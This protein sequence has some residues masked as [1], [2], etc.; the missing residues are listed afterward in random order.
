MM[1]EEF[2]ARANFEVMPNE[3]MDIEKKYADGAFGNC[4]KDEFCKLWVENGGIKEVLQARKDG[5]IELPHVKRYTNTELMKLVVEKVKQAGDYTKA[6]G[7]LDY[8]L[9]EK[10]NT[11][12]L[13]NY[14]FDFHA[15][16]DFGGSEGI[17]LDCALKGKF[18]NSG[19]D[20]CMMGTFKTLKDDLESMKIMAELGGILYFHLTSF[21]NQNLNSITPDEELK[22]LAMHEAERQLDSYLLSERYERLLE[23]G[24]SGDLTADESENLLK[25]IK[26]IEELLPQSDAQTADES[27]DTE[28]EM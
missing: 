10:Y 22:W 27:L 16:A 6:E 11:V 21:V 28:Q 3:Y 12:R 1:K 19:N 9:P 17:Y 23:K 26:E 8:F 13:T 7:I 24:K 4:D 20:C 25:Q 5:N 18:D 2:E 15:I 14:E